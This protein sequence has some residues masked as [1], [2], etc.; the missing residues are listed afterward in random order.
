MRKQLIYPSNKQIAVFKCSDSR[1]VLVYIC[2]CA[3]R[4]V[5][6][7]RG[8]SDV[9]LRDQ[10]FCA[11]Q[12]M[13]ELKLSVITE[14]DFAR[15]SFQKHYPHTRGNAADSHWYI[16]C[17]LPPMQSVHSQE[18]ESRTPAWLR[19]YRSSRSCVPNAQLHSSLLTPSQGLKR[20]K[21]KPKIFNLASSMTYLHYC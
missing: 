19:H 2:R 17:L 14:V 12:I 18:R 21:I 8:L 6:V 1:W 9:L 13:R 10:S 3:V 4:T 15:D 16:L 11:S 7:P 5:I 20:S